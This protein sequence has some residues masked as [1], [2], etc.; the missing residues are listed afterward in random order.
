MSIYVLSQLTVNDYKKF[1][2]CIRHVPETLAKYGGELVV[3]S[4]NIEVMEGNWDKQM[5]IVLEFPSMEKAKNWYESD[6]YSPY[7]AVRQEATNSSMVFIDD[8]FYNRPL[9]S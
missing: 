5:F 9:N 6:E 1:K 4:Q 2:E 3:A 7:K 8:V